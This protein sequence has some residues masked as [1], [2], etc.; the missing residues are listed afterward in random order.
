M[1]A[2]TKILPFVFIEW[3]AKRNLERHRMMG[4]DVLK[5]YPNV[6]IHIKVNK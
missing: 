3:Y 5:P 2:W 1:R 4:I 6:S